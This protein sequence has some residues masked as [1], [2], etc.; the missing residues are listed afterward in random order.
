MD[1]QTQAVL[2]E[3]KFLQ[4][5]RGTEIKKSESLDVSQ[6]EKKPR[7]WIWVLVFLIVVIASGI[8]SYFLFLK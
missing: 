1:E 3:Q 8:L 4:T 2:P 5:V 7:W 6:E